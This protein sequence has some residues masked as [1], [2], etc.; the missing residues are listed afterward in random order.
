MTVFTQ[1]EAEGKLDAVL[2][3][4]RREGEVRIQVKS[5]EE[6]VVKPA[7]PRRS[8]LDVRGVDLNLTS[9]EIVKA[10]RESRER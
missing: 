7:T 3:S 9:D 1:S 8:P 5:G 4:A 6:F 10:V 2:E